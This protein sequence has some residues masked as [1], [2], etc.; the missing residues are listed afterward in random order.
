[1]KYVFKIICLKSGVFTF[2]GETF[3]TTD[4][5][6]DSA[7]KKWMVRS[8]PNMMARRNKNLY[9]VPVDKAK[10]KK[11]EDNRSIFNRI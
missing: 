1:M 10:A 7:G 11:G 6:I 5:I 8:N 2:A 9:I 3:S 4:I